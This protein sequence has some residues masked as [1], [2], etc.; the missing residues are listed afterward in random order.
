[1]SLK[2]ELADFISY[3]ISEK[4]VSKNTVEAYS[5]DLQGLANYLEV[6]QIKS[7]TIATSEDLISYLSVLKNAQYAASSICRCLISIKTLYHFFKRE[8]FLKENPALHLNTPKL[9][10]TIPS[11]LSIDE[12]DL[13]LAQPSPKPSGLRDKAILELLYSSGLRVTELCELSIYSVD[14]RF[15]RVL[16]KGRK[17]RLVPLGRKALKAIDDYLLHFRDRFDSKEELRLFL[18]NKGKPLSRIGVWKMV[19][20]YAVQAE[21]KK[22]ISPHTF[23]HTF[24]THLLDNG[25]DLRVI[26]EMLGHANISSTDRYTHVSRSHLQEAFQRCHLR[27]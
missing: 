10:Q 23:R 12:I 22:T 15:V 5:R 25:A 17:E 1:M 11:I 16:G 21:I 13:L 24:A 27:Y 6:I 2:D 3:I 4:G 7:F 18:T 8:G 9:W 26:Q 14:D 19:K 20:K